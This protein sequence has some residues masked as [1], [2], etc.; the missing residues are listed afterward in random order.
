M[1]YKEASSCSHA[2]NFLVELARGSPA[3]IKL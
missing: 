2:L 3:A 1:K